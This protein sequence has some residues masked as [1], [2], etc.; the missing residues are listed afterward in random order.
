[1]V[2]ATQDR[3][4]LCPWEHQREESQTPVCDATLILPE[5]TS[6]T[7]GP[8]GINFCRAQQCFSV[9]GK[10][11]FSTFIVCVQSCQLLSNWHC[12]YR[13][14]YKFKKRLS[15]DSKCLW[16]Y[17]YMKTSGY[18]NILIFCRNPKKVIFMLIVSHLTN[19]EPNSLTA[20]SLEIS[21][22]TSQSTNK[23]SANFI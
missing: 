8:G 18:L 11:R 10:L 13:L 9:S 22:I 6:R 7:K 5:M 3:K 19:N 21:T 4:Q 2:L 23:C 1:M 15:F 16:I 12:V 14:H 17:V 20:N